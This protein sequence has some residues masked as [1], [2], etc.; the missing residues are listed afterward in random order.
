V[1]SNDA[2]LYSLEH[3]V[4]ENEF[5]EIGS[6]NLRV[7]RQNQNTAQLQSLNNNDLQQL[8]PTATLNQKL[9]ATRLES[10]D[11]DDQTREQINAAS[12]ITQSLYRLRLCRKP[13]SAA[14][15]VC[16]ASTFTFLR[17]I[18]D[19]GF[20][21]NL[22]VHTNSNNRPNAITIKSFPL[23]V[24]PVKPAQP[25][26]LVMFA[27]VLGPK[28][29]QQPDTETYLEKV[30][31]EVEIKEKGDQGDNQSFFSKYWIYI[32]PFVVIMFLVNLANP[33]GAGGS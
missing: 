2:D 32:V 12:S 3:A 25:S 14:A 29:A 27:T 9:Y 24:T 30:R 6:L 31:K 10:E 23:S 11:F 15:S 21:V 16:Y 17:N 28:P 22:T 4:D 1:L 8:N 26:H 20:N 7:I 5:R 19:S 33:E 18:L 13:S